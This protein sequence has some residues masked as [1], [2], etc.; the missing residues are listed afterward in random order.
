MFDRKKRPDAIF[1]IDDNLIPPLL[2]GLERA[3]VQAGKD[4]YV[5]AHCNWPKPIGLGEGLEHLGFD[6]REVLCAGKDLIDAHPEGAPSVKRL[7]P[8]R[9][10][11]ELTRPLEAPRDVALEAVHVST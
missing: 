11:G 6:V 9:F 1:V 7:V 10:L 3:G 5:L 8:A 4:V 2:A